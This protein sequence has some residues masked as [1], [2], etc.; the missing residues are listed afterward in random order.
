MRQPIWFGKI[1]R[2][3]AIILFGLTVVFSLM[4][5]IGSICVALGAEKYG[6]MAALAPFKWLYQLLVVLTIGASLYGVKALVDLVKNREAAFKEALIALIACL[7]LALVQVIASRILRGKSMPN[8]LRVYISLVTLL[9]FGLLRLPPVWNRT[10]MGRPGGD[11]GALAAGLSL[12]SAGVAI[13]TVQWWAGPA[14][15]WGGVNFADTW[16][17]QL[18]V[19]GWSLVAGSII[20]LAKAV[21]YRPKVVELLS[22]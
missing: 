22:T 11:S 5:G 6:S 10:G 20:P 3:V 12:F 7:G 18:A 2:I 14:H 8:D 17:T 1:I 16:H 13:L 21:K 15:T 9:V 4:A 19:L